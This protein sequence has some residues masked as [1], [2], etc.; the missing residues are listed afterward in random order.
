MNVHQTRVSVETV[1]R[2]YSTW[3]FEHPVKVCAFL[4]NRPSRSTRGRGSL[5]LTLLFAKKNVG[6]AR[7][8]EKNSLHNAIRKSN[9]R[10]AGW[11]RRYS[12]FYCAYLKFFAQRWTQRRRA[13]TQKHRQQ[14]STPQAKASLSICPISQ[15]MSRW[16]CS[17]SWE[18]RQSVPQPTCA[19]VFKDCSIYCV[20]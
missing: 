19:F 12:V 14:D 9:L 18:T 3:K 11:R 8:R 13:K 17:S 5:R 15:I 2:V 7:A 20:I 10:V 6:S 16:G 1:L 4:R